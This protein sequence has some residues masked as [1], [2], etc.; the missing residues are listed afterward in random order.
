[1]QFF[2][3]FLVVLAVFSV[4][5][6]AQAVNAAKRPYRYHESKRRVIHKKV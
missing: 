3:V 2:L 6:D 5:V 4:A 1:M